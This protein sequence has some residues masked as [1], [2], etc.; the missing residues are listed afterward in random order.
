[1]AKMLP[2]LYTMDAIGVGGALEAVNVN[3]F[4]S[5][6]CREKIIQDKGLWRRSSMRPAIVVLEA[7]DPGP[8]FTEEQAKTMPVYVKKGTQPA[9]ESCDPQEQCCYCGTCIGEK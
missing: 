1:M 5:D 8:C 4:C 3:R 2:V 7:N 6:N 9:G